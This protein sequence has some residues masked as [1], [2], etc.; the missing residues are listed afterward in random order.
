MG[1]ARTPGSGVF[2]GVEALEP[3]CWLTFDAGGLKKGRYWALESR[4]HTDDYDTTVERVRE[5]V[6]GAITRQLVQ[7]HH[8][9]GGQGSR[10]P[11]PAAPGDLLL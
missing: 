2:A 3:G 5:L 10:P 1:P 8:R 9:R 7:R 6:T 11:G 4:P